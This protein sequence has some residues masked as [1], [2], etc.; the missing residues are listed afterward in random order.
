LKGRRRKS[1]RW[2]R[3]LQTFIEERESFLVLCKREHTPREGD[4]NQ[5]E[6]FAGLE[7]GG[8]PELELTDYLFYDT[9]IPRRGEVSP[10]VGL[11]DRG[12][13]YSPSD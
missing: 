13:I 4:T 2:K 3:S 9:Q 1:F 8:Q 12:R 7:K 11:V 6:G 5:L 10:R